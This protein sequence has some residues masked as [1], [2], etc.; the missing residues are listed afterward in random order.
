MYQEATVPEEKEEK[1]QKQP[2]PSKKVEWEKLVPLLEAF[3][4]SQFEPL[5]IVNKPLLL[6]GLDNLGR[7]AS[8]GSVK[9]K[10]SPSQLRSV[11]STMDLAAAK[12]V[13]DACE[14]EGSIPPLDAAIRARCGPLLGLTSDVNEWLLETK[15][16]TETEMEKVDDTP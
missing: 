15:T 12:L 8:I 3:G 4:D 5:S 14:A 16:E 1:E 6:I 7:I 13:I 9:T 10:L 11:A 2:E